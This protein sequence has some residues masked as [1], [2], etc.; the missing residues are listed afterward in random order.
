MVSQI[1]N[2][3]VNSKGAVT[4]ARELDAIGASARETT[5]YLNGMRAILA[6]A[7]AFSGVGAIVETINTFT[8]L[9]NRLKQ[10]ADASTTVGETWKQLLAIANNSYSTIGNT[11]DLYFRVAQAYKA[12]GQGAKEALQFTDLFQKAAILSG[13]TMETTTQA[14]Y[15]FGQALNKGKLDGD[16]FRSVLEG[17]PYVA[18]IIQKSLGVTRA[19]L[20][21]LSKEGKISVDRIKEAFESAAGTI[22]S[23]WA[24]ITPTIAMAIT[25]L[26]NNWTDF[27]GSIQNSTGIFSG[28][29]YLIILVANHFNILAV[30]LTPIVLSL[31]FLA[32]RLGIGLVVT[33]F[34][35]LTEALKAATVVQ[36]LY[37]V[38][39]SA[40]PYVIA[41]VAI[42]ALVTAILYFSGALS[43]LTPIIS[44]VWSAITGMFSALYGYIS[45]AVSYIANLIVAF[46]QWA[47]VF[48]ALQAIAAATGSII[49]AMFSAIISGVEA[50][51]SYLAGALAPLFLNLI[52]MGTDFHDLIVQIVAAF[53]DLLTPSVQ[54]TYDTF[55]AFWT[56]SGPALTKFGSLLNDIYQG[57]KIIATFLKENFL[58][59]AKAV[60]EGWIF[61]INTV[62]TAISKIINALRTAIALMQLLSGLSGGGGGGGGGGAHY[63]A[64][65]EVGKGYAN[66]G[67]FKVG[68]DGAGRD[69]TPVMFRAERGERVTV[70]TK[71]QQRQS[72]NNS[73]A[74]SVNVNVPITNVLDPGMMVSAMGTFSGQRSQINTI[75]DNASEIRQIL[76]L[77]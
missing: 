72:D 20:Y 52:K 63:G 25:V 34:K 47:G 14:V 24:N 2:V 4:V 62:V 30:A 27:L 56:F 18:N 43:G 15:Q 1:I 70:E 51:A 49:S 75:K 57:W 74:P 69:Q 33:G 23:D 64:Q 37:N 5:T 55:K 67:S 66:G 28:I 54:S 11:V 65:F 39:V 19:E 76:G 13:S 53:K 38:A 35:D 16:E 71:K 22:R 3:I 58:P 45:I 60:F 46:V 7:L 6:A 17:L 73:R 68:G 10:V 48:T 77:V 41:A 40:N 32:G 61:L 29:A 9:T 21:K 26:K 44:A 12:W 31:G 42:A 50:V 8:S 59:V 36:W